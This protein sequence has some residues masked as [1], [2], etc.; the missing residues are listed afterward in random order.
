MVSKLPSI[1]SAQMIPIFLIWIDLS[2]VLTQ[3]HHN[4]LLLTLFPKYTKGG[5]GFYDLVLTNKY[6]ADYRDAI[7]ICKGGQ[8]K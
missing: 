2:V 4:K 7:Y 1:V 5:E 3:T 6:D 8:G